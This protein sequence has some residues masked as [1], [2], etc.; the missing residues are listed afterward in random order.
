[1]AGEAVAIEALHHP[2][3]LAGGILQTFA[4]EDCHLATRISDDSRSL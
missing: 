1:M 3:A 2:V 4:I